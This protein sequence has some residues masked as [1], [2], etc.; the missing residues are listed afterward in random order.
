M[1]GLVNGQ[2]NPDEP[3]VM[4]YISKFN[5]SDIQIGDMVVTSGLDSIFP[6]DLAIGRVKEIRL[7]EYDSSALIIIEP[8]LNFSK[9]EYLFVVEKQPP[10]PDNTIPQTES[11]IKERK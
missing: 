2:G 7:P 1:E 6:P 11:S 4:R 9:L 10:P 5:V 3:L 8:S